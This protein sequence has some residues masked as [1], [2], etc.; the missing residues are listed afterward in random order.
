MRLYQFS[1]PVS[2]TEQLA[3]GRGMDILVGSI[4]AISQERVPEV[5]MQLLIFNT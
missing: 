4:H 2:K 5:G 1:I 3:G